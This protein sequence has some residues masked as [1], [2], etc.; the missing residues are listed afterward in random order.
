M[1]QFNRDITKGVSAPLDDL[2]P[3]D[4]TGQL[5]DILQIR[6]YIY[7]YISAHIYLYTCIR[8]VYRYLIWHYDKTILKIPSK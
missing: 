2:L 6:V 5:Y 8:Y 1:N 4:E 3:R 7:V